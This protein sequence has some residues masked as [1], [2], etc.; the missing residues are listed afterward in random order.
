MVTFSSLIATSNT[1]SSPMQTQ[2]VTAVHLGFKGLPY[3]RT[4]TDSLGRKMKD[5]KGRFLREKEP[6][7]IKYTLPTLGDNT[8]VVSIIVPM[9]SE[10]AFEPM[11]V[12]KIVGKGYHFS[13]GGYWITEIDS[14]ETLLNMQEVEE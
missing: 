8:E 3:K 1:G 5:E 14:L 6:S 2:E 10:I 7:A 11:T 12:Y 13:S 4:L 9:G